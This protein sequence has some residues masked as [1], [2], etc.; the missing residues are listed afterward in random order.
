MEGRCVGRAVHWSVESRRVVDEA[1]REA[2]LRR[3]ERRMMSST[4]SLGRG[5]AFICGWV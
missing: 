1:G 4:S 5:F 2:V 3:E